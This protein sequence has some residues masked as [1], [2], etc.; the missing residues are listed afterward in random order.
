MHEEGITITMFGLLETR[1][2]VA[3][4]SHR[5]GTTGIL[6]PTTK[7]HPIDGNGT[8]LT[9]NDVK[10]VDE[11]HECMVLKITTDTLRFAL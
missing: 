7:L 5:T 9:R 10:V 3:D 4:R 1:T 2:L 8:R 11:G 6:I